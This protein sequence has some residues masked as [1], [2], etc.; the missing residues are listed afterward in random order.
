MRRECLERMGPD[1]L[2]LYGRAVGADVSHASDPREKARL[3]ERRRARTA[4]VRALGI[5]FEV[6]YKAL[7]DKRVSDLLAE[8]GRTDEQTDELIGLLLGEDQKG[9]LY[10]ACT[11][12]DGTVD[13]DALAYAFVRLLTSDEL[14]NL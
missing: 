13:V 10:A 14:K 2:D 12:E 9:E 3:I 4:V 8:R 6:P 1:E 5:D 7:H 11:D